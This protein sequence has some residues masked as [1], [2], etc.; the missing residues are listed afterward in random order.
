MAL[1][2][3]LT[4]ACD[5][6]I[7]AV[8]AEEIELS[9]TEIPEEEDALE[10]VIPD[11]EVVLETVIPDEENIPD[12][13]V[14]GDGVEV[15][16][17]EEDRE[18]LTGEYRLY[19]GATYTLKYEELD[20][21]TIKITGFD[22]D[23]RGDLV[24]PDTIEGKAV[25]EIGEEAFEECIGF[26]G[27]LRIG[28]NVTTIGD[29]AFR[30]CSGLT[31]S[32]TIPDSV[33]S[34]GV[35]AFQQ[36]TG[37]NGSLTIPDSVE[38]IGNYAFRSCTGFNGNL[39][40]SDS[41]ETIGNYAFSNCTGFNGSLTIGKNV[42]TIG[43]YAFKSCTG[44]NG[45]LTIQDSVTA[46]GQAAFEGCTGFNGS[47][48]IP[49]SVETIGNYAFN[50]CIGFNGNLAIGKNVTTIGEGAFQS[51]RGFRKVINC[52]NAA[53]K[54]QEDQDWIDLDSGEEIAGGTEIKNQTVIRSDYYDPVDVP[55]FTH[56]VITEGAYTGRL[57]YTGKALKPIEKVYFGKT[58]LEEKTDYT[59]TYRN[60]TNA[61]T[62]EF[63]ITGKG[64]YAGKDSDS[65]EILKKNLTD[66]DVTYTEPAAA[67]YTKKD[68]TPVPKITYNG[69]S[70]KKGKDFEVAYYADKFC[71]EYCIPGEPATYYIKITGIGNYTGKKVI[72]FVIVSPDKK[73]MSALKADKIADK[74]YAN[75]E[76]IEL[77]EDELIIR[78]GKDVL[79]K[80]THYTI[81]GYADNTLPGT[82]KITIRGIEEA[83]YVGSMTVTFNITGTPIGK[84]QITGPGDCTYDGTEKKPEPEVKLNGNPLNKGE[85]Y[86]LIYEKEKNINAGK[87][88]VTIKGKGGY[89]GSV[90]KTFTIKPADINIATITLEGESPYEYPY[91]K[92]GVKPA[93]TVK[94]GETVLKEGKDYTLKYA[95]NTAVTPAGAT[96][97]PTVTVTGKG[98]FTGKV[99]NKTFKITAANIGDCTVVAD[100]VEFKDKA[101]NWKTKKITI[102]GPDGKAL[103]AGTDYDDKTIK[104]FISD[105]EDSDE[106]DADA[107]LYAG[108]AVYVKVESKGAYTGTVKGSYRI[109]ATDINK[110]TASIDPKAYTGKAVTLAKEDIKWKSGSTVLDNVTFEVIASSY[111]NNVNKGKATVIVR[112]TDNY[113]GYKTIT[114]TIGAKDILWWWRNLFN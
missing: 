64:N 82:A 57:T 18:R 92:G 85:D 101:G 112:G 28:N 66:T 46:I 69:M 79:E 16:E 97:V 40:I 63:T 89:T 6:R 7:Y 111:T 30:L 105:E 45:N 55:Y 104:Y 27:N 3:C 32:L 58:L 87:A 67:K 4:L 108:D 54:L 34:I 41:V 44:F 49:D 91:V 99:D 14:P 90:T 53:Y 83:G 42:T 13:G 94:L 60:N 73:P 81:V 61:G 96:K 50:N 17:E 98:N 102:L 9:E 75:G 39:T 86:E 113:V 10:T 11:D 74:P 31:G 26:D 36:C 77:E 93:V 95:N 51:C 71:T 106:I 25:T 12:A 47:L 15:E 23:A 43:Q 35:Q 29:Y 107:K 38:T 22:G 8:M 19:E 110:L 2:V 88:K 59:V 56:N 114:Y 78:D 65:F 48:T 20:D 21:D 24:I 100:P 52:S 70:L 84:A 68:Q 1:L 109:A 103:K 5:S 76:A 62:A 80:D 72:P 37:F 33:T